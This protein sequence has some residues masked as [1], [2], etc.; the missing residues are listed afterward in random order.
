MNIEIPDW[1]RQQELPELEEIYT[2]GSP[3]D[4]AVVL[5]RDET[6]L[7]TF[8]RM[9]PNN[10]W[11]KYKDSQIYVG[12]DNQVRGQ[13]PEKKAIRKLYRARIHILSE[14]H[15]NTDVAQTHIYRNYNRGIVQVKVDDT[16]QIIAHWNAQISKLIFANDGTIYESTRLNGGS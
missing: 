11:L 16:W 13:N 4:T 8:L 14:Q 1:M 9:C 3:T 2:L 15:P 5:F 7:W 6:S 12:L 10:K